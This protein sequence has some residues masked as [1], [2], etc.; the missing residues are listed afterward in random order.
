MIFLV[1]FICCTC[2]LTYVS[3]APLRH[4]EWIISWHR[5]LTN[6]CGLRKLLGGVS[7]L[8]SLVLPCAL[9]AYVFG[10]MLVDSTLLTML[11]GIAVLLY[12]SGPGDIA[13]EIESYSQ[14]YMDEDGIQPPPDTNNFLNNIDVG[15]DDPDAPFLRAIAIETNDR[16]FGPVF[17]FSVL[18][19]MGAL[20]FRMTITLKQSASVQAADRE[21][22]TRLYNILIWIPA[23][24]LALGLGLGGTLA[25]VIRILGERNFGLTQ[26]DHLLG[27]TAIAA[28][29]Y[30]E[31]NTS[32][33]GDQ[34]IALLENMFNLI[35]R[36]FVVWLAV[37][38]LLAVAGWV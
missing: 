18:G 6:S 10:S 35:K 27:D 4:G 32:S 24:L 37:L 9:L 11:G 1:V 16:L 29:G 33:G 20:L 3:F 31:G 22:A 34:H 30:K 14:S 25:P 26:S 12:C 19:P 8:G 7:I 23:R 13:Q 2:E 5:W 21:L 38:A 28:L 17:W 15:V 36:G